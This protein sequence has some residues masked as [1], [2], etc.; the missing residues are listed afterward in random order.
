MERRR[1]GKVLYHAIH[2]YTIITLAMLI[3]VVGWHLFLLP[4]HIP[5]GGI[6]GVA[7]IIY[8]GWNVAP[9]Y[10]FFVINAI[11]LIAALKVLGWRFC[12][13]T[14]YGVV[15]FTLAS[16][17]I[18]KY[19]GNFNILADQ[20]F[21]ATMVGGVFM[22]TS[23]GLGLSAGGSTGGSD[24]IAAMIHKYRDISLGNVILFCDVAVIDWN[25]I[26]DIEH[27]YKLRLSV[28]IFLRLVPYLYKVY[29]TLVIPEFILWRCQR[30]T[31]FHPAECEPDPISTHN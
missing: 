11:L 17:F 29:L 12:I 16:A 19:A 27:A 7:S 8:W 31:G 6:T 26:V 28:R 3:G 14:I 21:M 25:H 10:S 13:K 4:N 5:M 23:V 1:E 22:G 15:V 2:D 18:Q 9:Q 20:K 30:N 24:V